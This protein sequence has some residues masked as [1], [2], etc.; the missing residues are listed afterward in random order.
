MWSSGTGPRASMNVTPS[1]E[2]SSCSTP[3]LTTQT[4]PS[5]MSRVS[6]PIVIVIEPAT[7]SI[8]CSVCSWLWRATVVPG[9][10]VTCPRN[11]WSPAMA[12]SPT[13][14]KMAKGSLPLNVENGESATGRLRGDLEGDP[15]LRDA[16]HRE[17][18]VEDDLLAHA[19]RLRLR[20]ERAQ[21]L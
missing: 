2:C 12:R 7:M 11:T 4:S 6:P 16:V 19:G 14:S 21:D 3:R 10:Y 20:L 9:A 1:A 5:R 8:A 18:G 13:P 15:A 17:L